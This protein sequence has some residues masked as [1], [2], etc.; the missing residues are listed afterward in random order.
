VLQQFEGLSGEL[1]KR[2]QALGMALDEPVAA[3]AAN[4][5]RY[6]SAIE[7]ELSKFSGAAAQVTQSSEQAAAAVD[8]QQESLAK[9]LRELAGSI[10]GVRSLLETRVGE[11]TG[12]IGDT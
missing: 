4:L 8:S 12:A 6:S 5:R 11:A 1:S 2:Y 9:Q 7:G 3:I 10:D